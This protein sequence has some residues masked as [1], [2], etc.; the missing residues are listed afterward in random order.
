[1][2]K[3]LAITILTLSTLFLS[4]Q[5]EAHVRWFVN[6]NNVTAKAFDPDM[7]YAL[8]LMGA[9]AFILVALFLDNLGHDQKKFS[10]LIH[11]PLKLPIHIEWQLVSIAIGIMLFMN[12]YHGILLAPNLKADNSFLAQTAIILQTILGVLLVSQLSYVLVSFGVAVLA[13]L[14][15]IIFPMEPMIDYVFEF[16]G[17]IIAFYFIGPAVSRIDGLI[18]PVKKWHEQAAICAITVGLGLQLVELS[19]HNKLTNPGLVLQFVNDNSYLNFIFFMGMDQ[20]TNMH[21]SFAGAVAELA[22]GIL[23]ILGIALRFTAIAI[24]TIFCLSAAIF[25]LEEFLGHLPIITISFLIMLNGNQGNL[26]GF[27]S[28]LKP[29]SSLKPIIARTQCNI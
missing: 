15:V 5:A 21:F 9:L 3:Y 4:T 22:F 25:G 20:F 2:R 29:T 6:A 24:G 16:G 8:I 12:S 28:S 19:I 17:V 26:I 10:R 11:S 1:M 7:I 27:L 13:I 14:C 23:L 18:W